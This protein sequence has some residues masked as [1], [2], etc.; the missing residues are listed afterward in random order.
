MLRAKFD[1]NWRCVWLNESAC[2]LEWLGVVEINVQQR[3]WA[4]ADAIRLQSGVRDV[5]PGMNN[6][7]V[8][9][10]PLQ[11]HE[12]EVET[13]L[14]SIRDIQCDEH[15]NGRLIDIPVQYGGEFGPDLSE[16]ASLTRLSEADVIR[17]HGEPIYTVFFLGFM[18]G[19]A[20]LGGMDERISCPRRGTPR[21]TVPSGAV[22]IGGSQTGI[23]PLA[24]P[25]GWQIIGRTATPLFDPAANPPTLLR[26]GDCVRFVQ[27]GGRT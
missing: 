20:Y 26:P 18:P 11:C 13:W 12:H 8:M 4:L 19:F 2:T 5:V 7:T 14:S 1:A 3:I 15:A 23:Y 16:V 17:L 9:L 10:D 22:A 21:L 27:A 25:G 24:S 6:L